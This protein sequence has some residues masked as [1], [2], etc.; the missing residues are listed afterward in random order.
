MGE[1]GEA[2]RVEVGSVHEDGPVD[3]DQAKVGGGEDEDGEDPGR[4]GGGEFHDLV[5]QGNQAPSHGYKE[6]G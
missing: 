1:G 3:E 4:P 6:E 5:S 2:R